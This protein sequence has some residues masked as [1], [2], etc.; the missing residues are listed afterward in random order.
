MRSVG[1]AVLSL[2]LMCTVG[3]AF[4]QQ[5][6][7]KPGGKPGE[8]IT[9]PDTSQRWQDRLAVGQVAPEFTLPLLPTATDN[10]RANASA[11][12]IQKVSLK[13]LHKD[14]PAVLIFGSV[15]CPPFRGQL[16]GVDA[17]YRDFS[18]RA[19]FLWVYIREAH[20]DS[21]LSLVNENQ[22]E[23]L[24]PVP[25]HTAIASRAAAAAACQRTHKLGI[26]I[27]V[28]GIDNAVGQA[29]AGWP[30]RMVVVGTDG[31][32]AF[33]SPGAPRGTDA[34]QLRSWLEQNLSAAGK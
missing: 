9:R 17:V 3:P 32:I 16:E 34:Q 1:L 27:A 33:L 13:D 19:E 8:V 29:Y 26:P 31:K 15:T 4:G 7:G 28:D 21:V 2:G 12:E 6:P 14:K 25:Q 30:N 18:D 22:Q 23:Q 20:P 11:N 24:M 5:R 10:K